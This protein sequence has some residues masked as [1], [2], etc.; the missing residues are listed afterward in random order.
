MSPA[1]VIQIVILCVGVVATVSINVAQMLMLRAE[2]G[3]LNDAM[4]DTGE[5]LRVSENRLVA[6]ETRLGL[7]SP[8][9]VAHA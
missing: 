1:E 4:K 6:V 9:G 5:R 2:V 8:K 3:R 7:N